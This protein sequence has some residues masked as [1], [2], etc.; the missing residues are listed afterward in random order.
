MTKLSETGE[1][2]PARRARAARAD[3]RRRAR[4]GGRRR[5]RGHAGRARRGRALP[6]RPAHVARARLPRRGGE[7]QRPR[8]VRRGSRRRCSSASRCRARPR[9]T[10]CVALYEGIA[11]AGVPVVGG[12]TT[13]APVGCDQRHR[14]RAQRARAR[15]C[16]CAARRHARRHRA[17]RRRPAPRSARVAI[18]GRRC[19]CTKAGARATAYA[20][21]DVSD[22]L[23]VDARPHRA[24]LGRS[25]RRR[26]RARS[27]RGRSDGRRPRLR[28][29]LRAARGRAGRGPLHSDRPGRGGGGRR[30]AAPRRAVRA[31][32]LGALPRGRYAANAFS[33]CFFGR[34]PCT[35][36]RGSPPANRI[37]V[38][39]ESTP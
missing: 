27:A 29:G 13:A 10:T 1:L 23:A 11:E 24:P 26:A 37:T 30:A 4:R 33:K 5:A 38:G 8:R 16:R 6:A 31:R 9:S 15:P 3:R 34:A 2:A 35:V 25:L 19:A 39:S 20:Q 21:M 7:H 22:G 17:A 28:R 36:S 12:D 32:R 14:A 18:S